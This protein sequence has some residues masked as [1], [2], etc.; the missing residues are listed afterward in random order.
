[1]SLRNAF[2]VKLGSTVLSGLTNI[3]AQMNPEVDNEVNLGSNWPQFA[4]IVSQKPKLMFSSRSVASCLGLLGSTGT[5]I[6]GSTNLIAY[7]AKLDGIGN[8]LSGTV[9]RSYTMT[10]GIIM[11]R[12]LSCQHRQSAQLD[13]EAVLYS[14]D[15]AAHP[16]AISDTVALP[17]ISRA[18]VQ[19]T[20]GPLTLGITGTVFTVDDPTSFSI[21]FGNGAQTSG[22]GSDIYDKYIEQQG[23]KPVINITGIDAAMFGTGKVPPVG[24]AITHA[25][26]SLFLRKRAENG[27]GFVANGTAEHIK[28][29][30]NGVAVVTDHKGTGNGKSEVSLQITTD[31][32]GTNAPIVIDTASAIS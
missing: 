27:I 28:I 26:V 9:H 4:A 23:I 14:S 8:P 21:D 3:D 16:I 11:P 12:R 6:D 7:F 15:G 20:I 22:S 1:M 18:Y 29:T 17:T 2:A 30:A 5:T 31:W 32:D 24:T 25:G 10:R 19:H 13:V